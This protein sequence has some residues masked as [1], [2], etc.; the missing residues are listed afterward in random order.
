MQNIDINIFTPEHG[1][2]GDAGEEV[3]NS[4]YKNIPVIS[5]YVIKHIEDSF[6]EFFDI[7]LFDLQDVGVRFY[8]YPPYTM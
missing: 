2:N 4:L 6:F 5:L 7:V 3:E 8:T 1:L